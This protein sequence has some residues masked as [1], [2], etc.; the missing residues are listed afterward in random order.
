MPRLPF[1]LC[2]ALNTLA[3]ALAL[4]AGLVLSGHDGKISSYAAA[5][6]AA[7]SVQYFALHKTKNT[8]KKTQ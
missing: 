1:I 4:I 7:A 8:H 3:A 5:I 6:L 2:A